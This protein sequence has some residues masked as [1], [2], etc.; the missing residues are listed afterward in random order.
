MSCCALDPSAVTVYNIDISLVSHG[1]NPAAPLL[2]AAGVAG[3]AGNEGAAFALSA[4]AGPGM[5]RPAASGDDDGAGVGDSESVDAGGASVDAFVRAD[6]AAAGAA[7]VG[8]FFDAVDAAEYTGSMRIDAPPPAMIATMANSGTARS[9]R[10]PG[11]AAAAAAAAEVDAATDAA[12]VAAAVTAAAARDGEAASARRPRPSAAARAR[13]ITLTWPQYLDIM[14]PGHDPG[15]GTAAVHSL[16]LTPTA[17]AAAARIRDAVAASVLAYAALQE[18]RRGGGDNRGPGFAPLER[19]RALLGRCLLSVVDLSGM[20][21]LDGEFDAALLAARRGVAVPA[22]A[23]RPPPPPARLPAYDDPAYD[24]EYGAEYDEVGQLEWD[25]ERRGGSAPGSLDVGAGSELAG[26]PRTPMLAAI[27]FLMPS[28]Y[29]AELCLAG[30][31]MVAVPDAVFALPQ[32]RLQLWAPPCQCVH[33]GDVSQTWRLAPGVCVCV[34]VCV[35]VF[36]SVTQGTL[37]FVAN[38]VY[39][40]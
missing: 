38:C 40:S 7:G 29:I 25:T 16:E 18:R 23:P 32:V 3:R 14:S 28:E 35:F 20:G 13:G 8:A 26:R 10:G 17:A 33:V 37:L 39:V 4:R 34:C 22:V 19:L 6:D 27:D 21:L 31:A 2:Q 24:A 1:C 9:P 11:A 5:G 15:V 12:M 36:V 30:N